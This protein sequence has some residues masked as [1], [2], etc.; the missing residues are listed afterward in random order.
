MKIF[1]W[2]LL[3]P[4]VLP[5][6]TLSVSTDSLMKHVNY[7]A[8][9]A[10][11]GRLP[12]TDGFLKAVQYSEYYF[13]QHELTQVLNDS[14]QQNI[15]I[16][17][18][19]I[20]SA[21]VMIETGRDMLELIPGVDFSVRG[22][23][24]SGNV[25][26]PVVFCGYGLDSDVYSDYRDIDVK[27]KIVLIFKSIPPFFKSSMPDY[28]IRGATD[29]AY[30]HGAVA[31]I[32][33][34]Q[35]NQNHP[36]EPIGSMMHG[37][38][39][40]HADLPQIQISVEKA[41]YLMSNSGYSLKQLQTSIDSLKKPCSIAAKKQASV[42]VEANYNVNG[43]TTNIIAMLPGS[44]P[45]LKDEYIILGAHLDH[46]G[47][48]G[49][50][51]YYP[52]A[53][54]NASGSV[55]VLELARIFSADRSKL[56]RS[57]IFVLFGSE[58]KGLDGSTYFVNNLPV[59]KEK[60]VAVFNMD[61]IGCGDSLM[62]GNGKSCPDLWNMA[63]GIAQQ[64]KWAV[65]QRTWEGGGADLKPFYDAGIPGLYFVNTNAHQQLH[66][67]SDTPEILNQPQFSRMVM[68]VEAV[69]RKLLM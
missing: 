63:I 33:V 24:G 32:F 7:F 53:N 21:R 49:N 18:N 56:K 37:A 57:V 1:F 66:L 30:K 50:T 61:C 6:Q 25:T 59:P 16:E 4:V 23:S 38:G 2:I 14:W 58:E 3:F 64:N 52:G 20:D 48:I 15:P 17:T 45:V 36:Q 40:M 27:G 11:N 34:S 42:Y 19:V 28:S 39:P 54:D 13:E 60:I 46:V 68:W 47:A 67:P 43:K 62:A 5:A 12:G 31:V 69:T 41:E 22:Y 44:D 35:P 55:A 9:P 26:A 8:S 29:A 65:S 51:V 10:L